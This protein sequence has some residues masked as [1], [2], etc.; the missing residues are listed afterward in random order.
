MSGPQMSEPMYANVNSNRRSGDLPGGEGGSRRAP[1]PRPMRGVPTHRALFDFLAA[2][3][4]E[5]SFSVGDVL[6]DVTSNAPGTGE[7]WLHAR[8]ERTGQSGL[9]PENFL[10]VI[11]PSRQGT[12]SPAL[13]AVAAA[14]APAAANSPST[15]LAT[16]RLQHEL[17][18]Q[19]WVRN[20]GADT[21]RADWADF[22]DCVV[23]DHAQAR[24]AKEQARSLLD[25]DGDGYVTMLRLNAVTRDTPASA[26]VGVVMASLVKGSCK[27]LERAVEAFHRPPFD[28]DGARRGFDGT[29]ADG[30]GAS[31]LEKSRAHLYLL[32][33]RSHPWSW[34]DDAA[35][36]SEHRREAKKY[37]MHAIQQGEHWDAPRAFEIGVC[38]K[39]GVG[40]EANDKLALEWFRRAAQSGNA[41][42]QFF[43]GASFA[44]ID[45]REAR[46]WYEL[47][48]E[49]NLPRARRALES[50]SFGGRPSMAPSAPPVHAMSPLPSPGAEAPPPYEVPFD[51]NVPTPP[52]YDAV[53]VRGA[54]YAIPPF[55]GPQEMGAATS[56]QFVSGYMPPQQYAPPMVTPPPPNIIHMGTP[57]PVSVISV[58]DVMEC[59]E[60]SSI[61]ISGMKMGGT[62][63]WPCR[64]M[65]IDR[66]RRG[67][68]IFI[69]YASYENSEW[70]HWTS[71]D[72]L[73]PVQGPSPLTTLIRAGDKV[74]GRI[75]HR[76]TYMWWPGTATAV[77]PSG[78]TI[79]FVTNSGNIDT[80]TLPRGDVR[81]GHDPK[82]RASYEMDR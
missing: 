7:G 51:R 78:V 8:N 39:L 5:L 70:S 24:P 2:D 31:D 55:P 14:A 54:S 27:L 22:W 20:W 63:W 41:P 9:V 74:E 3:G 67:R 32:V 79:R 40:V 6:S 65:R 33:I 42:A 11:A 25:P 73:R 43:V 30:S 56:V 12:P 15:P 53:F 80:I 49:R 28:D 82:W 57:V 1:P 45:D 19:F 47:A 71:P 50:M 26:S 17:A 77:D 35:A 46:S 4:A 72:F 48:A 16:L 38:H 18:R 59:L 58:G 34:S 75:N 52:T 81:L 13:P 60:Q 69:D 36:V 21:P 62:K 44:G 29:L 61:P 66:N 37:A 23:A 10:E 64:V 76:Q 68:Q